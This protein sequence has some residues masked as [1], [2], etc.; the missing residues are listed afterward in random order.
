MNNVYFECR[1]VVKPFVIKVRKFKDILSEPHN[2]GDYVHCIKWD[3][4]DNEYS[5]INSFRLGFKIN[6]NYLS[7]EKYPV[8]TIKIIESRFK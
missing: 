8:D 1:K 5:I 4:T 3:E 6:K 2:V 7:K